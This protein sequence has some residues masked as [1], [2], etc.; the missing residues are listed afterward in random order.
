MGEYITPEE[1]RQRYQNLLSWYEEHGHLWV[2]NGPFY[3]ESLGEEQVVLKRFPEYPDPADKWLFLTQWDLPQV[4]IRDP[5]RVT[6][7]SGTGFLVDVRRN[8]ELYPLE[9]V[10]EMKYL[11]IDS[12][13][14]LVNVGRA[15]PLTAGQWQVTLGPEATE[16]LS[17]GQGKLIVLVFLPGCPEVPQATHTF[18]TV[19][20]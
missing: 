10:L 3:L 18:Q 17:Q 2:G 12:T 1:A 4:E 14:E 5:E 8:G 13:G 11:L 19:A 7:G 15:E 20:R 16:N 6:I 9:Q